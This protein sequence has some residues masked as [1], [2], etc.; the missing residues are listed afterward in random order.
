MNFPTPTVNAFLKL[1]Q[2][3]EVTARTDTKITMQHVS[4]GASGTDYLTI[5]KN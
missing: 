1:N 5:E 3:W 4:G 2:D